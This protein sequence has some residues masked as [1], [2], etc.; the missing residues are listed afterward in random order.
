MV[1][2]KGSLMLIKAG[3]GAETESFSTLGGSGR[4]AWR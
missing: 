1:A 4:A 2:Q 3:D